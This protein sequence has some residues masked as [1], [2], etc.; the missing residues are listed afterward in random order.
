[1]DKL[2]LMELYADVIRVTCGL[3]VNDDSPSS[4]LDSEWIIQYALVHL[5]D[6]PSEPT[7]II[8]AKPHV[9][10]RQKKQGACISVKQIKLFL[11]HTHGAQT[12][13]N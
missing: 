7:A 13:D 1:M 12:P 5:R 2:E 8:S 6:L 10:F 3:A 4:S 11:V 9:N